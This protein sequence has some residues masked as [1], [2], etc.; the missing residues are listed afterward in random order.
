MEISLR[1]L[2]CAGTTELEHREDADAAFVFSPSREAD[3][4][5]PPRREGFAYEHVAR[6]PMLVSI[7]KASDLFARERVSVTDLGGHAFICFNDPVLV[8]DAR[9][10]VGFMAEKG[11]DVSLTI[12]QGTNPFE[13]L[14]GTRPDYLGFWVE[15][16]VRAGGMDAQQDFRFVQVEGLG[17]VYDT[18]FMYRPDR[19]H[20]PQIAALMRG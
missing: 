17:V 3:A 10:A 9:A 12:T 1:S 16:V 11:A 19:P 6:E 20:L 14:Y 18:Y 13:Y 15:S 8:E 5:E 2:V 4:P 7:P